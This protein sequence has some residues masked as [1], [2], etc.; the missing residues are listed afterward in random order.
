MANEVLRSHYSNQ[1]EVNDVVEYIVN[2]PC[3]WETDEYY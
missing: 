3:K 2:N 1:K